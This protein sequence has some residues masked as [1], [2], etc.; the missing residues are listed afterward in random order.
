MAVESCNVCWRLAILSRWKVNGAEKLKKFSGIH[1]MILW[2]YKKSG[3]VDKNHLPFSQFHLQGC[4]PS[5]VSSIN[6]Q[7]SFSENAANISQS[8]S[9]I[10]NFKDMAQT[11]LTSL[12]SGFPFWYDLKRDF[13]TGKTAAKVIKNLS[14]SSRQDVDFF[15]SYF[16][17]R[18]N[19]R[20]IICF[21]FF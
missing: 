7:I 19:S 9:I 16:V 1:W 8:D 11:L 15:V 21:L 12:W 14:L 4:L 18:K 5:T 17:V 6:S 13:V 20:R 2:T 3:K 10:C